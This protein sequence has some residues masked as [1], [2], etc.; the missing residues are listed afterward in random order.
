[1]DPTACLRRFLDACEE[2]DREEASDALG[3]LSNW[4][5]NGG[6]LPLVEQRTGLANNA[7]NVMFNLFLTPIR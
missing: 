6:F 7:T 3:D 5:R 1:M 2:N 4:I